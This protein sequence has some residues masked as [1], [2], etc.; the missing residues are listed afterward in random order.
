MSQSPTCVDGQVRL[1]VH[2]TVPL[3]SPSSRWT[4][5]PATTR[6]ELSEQVTLEADTG[7][8]MATNVAER[9]KGIVRALVRKASL[10]QQRQAA[11]KRLALDSLE[12]GAAADP[13]RPPPQWGLA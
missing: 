5:T 10:V 13:V 11:K 2:S 4:A 9:S 3:P 7:R 8:A 12:R 1:R 6:A